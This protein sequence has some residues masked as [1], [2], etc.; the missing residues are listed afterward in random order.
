LA[1][2][3]FLPAILLLMTSFTRIMIVLCVEPA[4]PGAGPA[5]RRRRTR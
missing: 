4:A 2:L 3:S 1:A 5:D